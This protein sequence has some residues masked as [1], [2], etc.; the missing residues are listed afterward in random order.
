MIKLG[1]SPAKFRIFGQAETQS[2]FGTPTLS[3]TNDG[4]S[5]ELAIRFRVNVPG[6]ILAIR[7]WKAANDLAAHTGRLWSD[8]GSLMAS[9]A[10]ANETSSGW[11]QQYFSKPITIFPDIYYRAA[12]NSS[13]GYAFT[14]QGFGSATSKANLY[15]AVGAGLFTTTN[16]G[17]PNSSFNNNNYYRDIIFVPS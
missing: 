3:S 11:Q 12:V 13:S 14:T 4:T 17:F 5:Y 10:F 15:A 1:S 6:Q 7:Y 2:F 16:S 8:L 9:V